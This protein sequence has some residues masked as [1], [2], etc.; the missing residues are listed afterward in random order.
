[1]ELC[2]ALQCL[3]LSPRMIIAFVHCHCMRENY[4]E[5]IDGATCYIRRYKCGFVYP[6]NWI[7]NWCMPNYSRH[8]IPPLTAVN[9]PKWAF[10]TRFATTDTENFWK[11]WII[12]ENSC[13]NDFQL[14][15][16][17]SPRHHT[18]PSRV[19]AFVSPSHT[20]L[21][22]EKLIS[23]SKQVQSWNNRRQI[24]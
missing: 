18:P 17:L 1:M 3:F 4:S 7:V 9:R 20:H 23:Y 22:F 19:T 12:F 5:I 13:E 16:S 2:F 11:F 21:E 8:F 24:K 14:I 15:L 10:P 6:I